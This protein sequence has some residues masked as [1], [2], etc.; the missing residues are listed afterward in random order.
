MRRAA[1]RLTGQDFANLLVEAPDT[2]MHMAVLTVFEGAAAG[3]V[4]ERLLERV[5]H[6]IGLRLNGLP[7]LRRVLVPSRI[8]GGRPRWAEDP[9]FR[10]ELHVRR[11]DVPAPGGDDQLLTVAAD[12]LEGV[13]DRSRPLWELWVLTGLAGG[14][15]AALLK[16]H[17]SLTDGYGMLQIALGLFDSAT[18]QPGSEPGPYGRRRRPVLQLAAVPWQVV[19]TVTS[20]VHRTWHG[21]RA[22]LLRPIGTQRRLAVV[23]LEL[24]TVKEIAHEH[25][26]KVN[27]VLLELAAAGVREALVGRRERVG[28]IVL[29]ALM[30]VSPAAAIRSREH[31]RAASIVVSL[32]LDAAT[33]VD[34]LLA[35]AADSRR[36]RR[37]QRSGVIERAMVLVAR[38]PFGRFLS[39]RQ[40]VVDLAVSNLVGPAG[41]L[42]LLGD[43]MVEAIPITPISGNVSLDF[44]ALSYAGHLAVGILAD[45]D[46]WPD[47]PF[48]ARGMRDSAIALQVDRRP[49]RQPAAGQL[50]P[51]S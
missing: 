31:N 39:R 24:A 17:H 42:G 5:R 25:G 40:R 51:A 14:R 36:A 26:A 18:A 34:R 7:E 3:D 20:V 32:P 48:V 45:A 21:R 38:T 12:L 46:A 10:V 2:P 8:P 37:W 44:C 16:V 50:R 47:L 23:R 27:D 30:A 35:I 15:W 1:V 4:P 9:G 28:G 29:R 22:R 33:P 13:L 6:A 11:A 19:A 41:E 49:V 43:R